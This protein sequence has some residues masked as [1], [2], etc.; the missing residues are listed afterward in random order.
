MARLRSMVGM[1]EVD[2]AAMRLKSVRIGSIVGLGLIR[3]V[4]A[5]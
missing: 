2:V 5:V 4:E 3:E 1:M